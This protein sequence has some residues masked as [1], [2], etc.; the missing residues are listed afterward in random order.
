MEL[1]L[2]VRGEAVFLMG[3]EELR[4]FFGSLEFLYTV[5]S[6]MYILKMIFFFYRE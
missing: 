5:P 4:Q 2:S 3:L 1:A 6:A